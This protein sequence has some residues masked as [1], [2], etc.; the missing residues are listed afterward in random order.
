MNR[1]GASV[2]PQ[3]GGA[4]V[5][6]R[7]SRPPSSYFVTGLNRS[8]WALRRQPFPIPLH[9]REPGE[10]EIN[11]EIRWSRRLTSEAAI[12]LSGWP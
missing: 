10:P 5:S 3:L 11:L 9:L 7:E 8:S 4:A 12:A 6:Q 2:P 1:E